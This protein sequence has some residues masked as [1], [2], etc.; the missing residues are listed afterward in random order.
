MR[1]A[2][3]GRGAQH[4]GGPEVAIYDDRGEQRV[5]K[6]LFLQPVVHRDH[7]R[8]PLLVPDVLPTQSGRLYQFETYHIRF[9]RFF[10]IFI[11][12]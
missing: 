2:S 1:S 3:A 9:L 5:V 11:K 6:K 12:S 10:P 4:G 7:H 8:W